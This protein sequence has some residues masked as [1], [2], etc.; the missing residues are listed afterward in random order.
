[1]FDRPTPGAWPLAVRLTIGGLCALALA[2]GP[3]AAATAKPDPVFPSQHQV[4]AAKAKVASTADQVATLTA[5]YQA[6]SVQLDN[7]QE[8]AAAAGEAYN[9]AKLLL[10][11]R[12]AAA[13]TAAAAASS[14]AASADEAQKAIRQFAA[15]AYQQDGSLANVSAFMSASGPQDMID[16]ATALDT[17]GDVRTA[18]YAKAD[19]ASQNAAAAKRNSALAAAQQKEAADQ[20]AMAL[21]DAQAKADAAAA[22]AAAIQTH[23]AQMATQLASL[24]K[25]SVQVEQARQAGLRAEAIAQAAAE[26]AARQARI[27]AAKAERERTRKAAEEAARAKAAAEL[28]AQQAAAAK[29]E[30]E[31]LAA[32]AKKHHG[33]GSTSRPPSGGSSQP[34]PPQPPASHGGVSSVIAYAQAQIG[35]W[36]VWGAAGPNTFDCSGLTLMAWRQAGVYLD[37]YTGSQYNQTRRVAIS[38]LRPGDLVFYG[39]SGPTSHHVGLYVGGGQMIEAPHTGAQVRYASIYRSDLLPYGG[40]P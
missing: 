34:T 10:D 16:R 1:M 8:A 17:M 19:A 40:R 35:K 30:A 22:E 20:A 2:T 18:A 25:T 15:L 14:A 28:A 36:Y 12:S 29:R 9:G 38:D 33:S 32:E 37:H 11:Q 26:E 31:R 39:D 7:V 24:Q 5:Q 13:A 6:A 4:D 27:A 3:I 23:Q 21:S